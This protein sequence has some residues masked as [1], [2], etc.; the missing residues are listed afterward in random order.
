MSTLAKTPLWQ[1]RRAIFLND[2]FRAIA[3]DHDLL[4]APISTGMEALAKRLGRKPLVVTWEGREGRGRRARAVEKR[5]TIKLS[6]ATLWRE[7]TKWNEGGRKPEALLLAY[8]P[9]TVRIPAELIREWQRLCTLATGARTKAG[10]ATLKPVYDSLCKKW[11][12]GE[13]IP[14]LGTWEDWWLTNE[15]TKRF[16]LPERAPKFPYTYEG[17]FHH[18]P[19]KQERA[20][21]NVGRA[22]ANGHM[23]YISLD[24]ARL[25]KCELYTADDV[26]L[27][28]MCLDNN[29]GRPVEVTAYV[30][31]EAASRSIVAF[32][33]KPK[34]AIKASDFSDLIAR[35]LQTPGYGLA[36]DC[37]TRLLL[38]R[39]SVTLSREAKETLEALSDGRLRVHYTGMDSGIRW[40]GAGADKGSG[41]AMG[42]SVIEAFNGTVHGL[43]MDLPGQRGNNRDHQ[44]AN[45]GLERLGKAGTTPKFTRGSTLDQAAQVGEAQ[46][47][48]QALGSQERLA[49]PILYFSQVFEAV[50]QAVDTYN[51]TPGRDL[52]GHGQHWTLE[53]APGVWEPYDPSTN[54]LLDDDLKPK[55]A[56]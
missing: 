15:D 23:T 40:V 27:D 50:R 34:D 7:W 8:K 14:G 22:A 31:M 26:R 53:T 29:T 35:G 52:K 33:C 25:R 11:R 56:A 39:G 51:K 37:V 30:L 36:R 19:R 42:K 44:P 2:E 43:L 21:G 6:L 45:L 49:P 32:I 12:K 5:K 13:C 46:K 1:R 9:G 28:L 24:W 20:A 54:T 55:R 41:H 17:L 48:L 16:H 10:F 38:E 4:G 3:S 47:T 18:R